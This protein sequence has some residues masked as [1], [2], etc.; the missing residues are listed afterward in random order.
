MPCR[1]PSPFSLVLATL[2]GLFVAAP[3]C[4]FFATGEQ[5]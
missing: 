2:A 3:G 5:Q 1:R 4:G